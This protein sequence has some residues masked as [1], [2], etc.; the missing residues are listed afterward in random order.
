MPKKIAK[1][2]KKAVKT[3]SPAPGALEEALEPPPLSSLEKQ[4]EQWYPLAND[5]GLH[6]AGVEIG[7]R[8]I[9]VEKKPPQMRIVFRRGST[10][11]YVACVHVVVYQGTLESLPPAEQLARPPDPRP[12][13]LAPEEHFFALNSYVEGLA[14]VGLGVMFHAAREAGDYPIGFNTLMQQQVRDALEKVAPAAMLDF[15]LWI[16]DDASKAVRDP[17]KLA[18]FLVPF[19]KIVAWTKQVPL[20]VLAPLAGDA[21]DDV[22]MIATNND[23]WKTCSIKDLVDLASSANVCVRTAVALHWNTPPGALA[24]LAGDKNV[25]VRRAIAMHKQTPPEALARLAGDAN[26]H[27]RRKVACNEHTPAEA[28]ARM[29]TSCPVCEI[30]GTHG[31]ADFDED[32]ELPDEFRKLEIVVKFSYDDDL[33]RCPICG[34]YYDYEFV[35]HGGVQPQMGGYNRSTRE[36]AEARIRAEKERIENY[37]KEYSRKVRK[38]HKAVIDTLTA[39]EKQVFDYLINRYC[40]SLAGWSDA[41][42]EDIVKELALDE[43]TIDSALAHLVELK[44]AESWPW[45]RDGYHINT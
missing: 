41:R 27:V 6:A 24:Q 28:I 5:P 8:L 23:T 39:V 3:S 21:N 34:T 4:R 36:K 17:G 15:C 11:A 16:M 10:E 30:L 33:R 43:K 37:T 25:N 19:K 13:E 2:T 12:V 44:V 32:M 9:F 35:S 42:K 38:K 45:S 26:L 20:E 40:A 18:D 1:M 14:V 7:A 29:A 31:F 22:R